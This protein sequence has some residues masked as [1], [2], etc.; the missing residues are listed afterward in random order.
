MIFL[1][2]ENFKT[3]F[4]IENVIVYRYDNLIKTDKYLE[5]AAVLL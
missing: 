3:K 2:D 4:F 1:G 5:Q